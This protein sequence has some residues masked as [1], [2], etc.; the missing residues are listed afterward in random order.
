VFIAC[1]SWWNSETDSLKTDTWVVASDDTTHDAHWVHGAM[2]KLFASLRV[3]F[4][5]LSKVHMFSDGGPHHFRLALNFYFTVQLGHSLNLDLMWCFHMANHGKSIYD[6]EGGAVKTMLMYMI[7]D[8]QISVECANQFIEHAARYCTDPKSQHPDKTWNISRRHFFELGTAEIDRS[9]SEAWQVDDIV[10]IHKTYVFRNVRGADLRVDH[11]CVETRAVACICESC[12]SFGPGSTCTSLNMCGPW[13][14]QIFGVMPSIK[15]GKV[16][17]PQLFDTLYRHFFVHSVSLSL[18]RRLSEQVNS[19]PN[20]KSPF[21]TTLNKGRLDKVFAG[22]RAT[23]GHDDVGCVCKTHEFVLPNT[24]DWI[25]GVDEIVR[26]VIRAVLW[27]IGLSRG[28]A[29]RREDSKVSEEDGEQD[30][31]LAEARSLLGLSGDA[32][33]HDATSIR[34]AFRQKALV[35]HPDK[36]GGDGNLFNQIKTAHDM[37]LRLAPVAHFASLVIDALG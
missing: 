11:F 28:A 33:E 35:H 15:R 19:Q 13:K 30:L 12:L 3:E 34:K 4:P 17:F 29:P 25:D 26:K 1:I 22:K 16:L 10:E 5:H 27:D 21:R 31:K 32:K 37:L 24:E 14:R 9:F 8:G 23:Q 2:R 6:P 36:P 20:K 18:F 7:R